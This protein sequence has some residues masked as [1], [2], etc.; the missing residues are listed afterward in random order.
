LHLRSG[1]GNNRPLNQPLGQPEA[2]SEQA[3]AAAHLS[4]VGFVVVAGKVEQAVKHEHLDFCRE[5]VAL[6]RGLAQGGGDADSEVASNLFRTGRRCV[7]RERKHVCGLVL[8]AEAAVQAADCGVG[9]KQN[10]DLAAEPHSSLR[11]SEKAPQCAGG[12]Q[13]KIDRFCRRTFPLHRF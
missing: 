9:R 1:F 5:R 12:G 6:F 8:V 3:L 10:C 4:R 13:T 7:R 2:C 11:L